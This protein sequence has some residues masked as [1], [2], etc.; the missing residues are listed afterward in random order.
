MN[1]KSR[2]RNNIA[3]L[4]VVQVGTYL[5]PLI[6]LPYVTRVLGIE[7]WGT[8]ALVQIVLGYFI[9]VTNWGFPMSG[10][11]KVAAYRNEPDRVTDIFLA[12]WAAQWLICGI[13]IL[14]LVLLVLFVPFFNR[15]AAYFVWGVGSIISSVL[16]PVWFLNGLER[17]RQ[18]ATIQIATRAAAV[19]LIF[20]FIHR[21]QDG[22][23]LLAIGAITSL[24]GGAITLIWI[25]KNIGLTWR[26]PGR[27]RILE[28]LREGATIF[29]STVWASLYTTLTPTILGL[30]AGN[31]AV[32]YYVLADRARQL[33]QSALTP[34]TQALFPRISQ[35]FETDPTQA[36]KL[37][38]R[39]STLILLISGSASVSLWILAEQIVILLSGEQFR[40]AIMVLKWLAPL[41]FVVSLSNIFGVQIMLPNHK[42]KAFNRILVGAGALS[43]VLIVPL[44]EWKSAVG[45]AI[46]VFIIECFVTL[47]M[48]L[49]L[50]TI[51]FFKFGTRG[52]L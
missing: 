21:P 48:A 28:E 43:L 25:N 6:T 27:A 20:L 47:T 40:P 38:L 37:L 42:T 10:T 15:Y 14:I 50:L 5:I 18:V 30:V 31:A 2:L 3:A 51:G 35:L 26:W 24:V 13:A 17:M 36:R 29:G 22:P 19:P 16:F 52:K 46:N 7:T 9:L 45:A 39:S 8:V 49:Y 32:G 12:A 11:R 44:I 23:I 41:P 1:F 4:G 33:G 34:I